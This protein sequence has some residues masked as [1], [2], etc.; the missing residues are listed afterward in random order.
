MSQF[1]KA[2]GATVIATTSSFTKAEKLKQLGA[3]HVI[4]Y[5]EDTNWGQTARGLTPDGVGVDHIIEVGGAN[6]LQQS[7]EAIKFEGV[8]T[9]IGFLGGEDVTQ[10]MFECFHKVCIARGAV[11]GSR[12]MM[13]DMVAA[14]EA[15][16]IH[17]VVDPRVFSF[18]QAK[19]AYQ[20]LV[21]F[22]PKFQLGLRFR[23]DILLTNCTVRR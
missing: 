20:Y 3:D 16:D 4:N 15:N 9:I 10:N 7:L 23:R 11:V 8:I 12:A 21:S 19:E 2:A 1:A 13:E 17:P 6:S 22:S 5:K 14:I 18:D